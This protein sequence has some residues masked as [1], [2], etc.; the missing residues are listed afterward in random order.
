M[1]QRCSSFGN[2]RELASRDGLS[3]L[4]AMSGAKWLS[5]RICAA[6]NTSNAGGAAN[7]GG[8]ACPALVP[9]IGQFL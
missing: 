4:S 8:I 2:V 1:K 9:T 5:D 6:H 3:A 7:V